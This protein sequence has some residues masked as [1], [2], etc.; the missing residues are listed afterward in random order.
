M[1]P[2]ALP[3]VDGKAVCRCGWTVPCAGDVRH[4]CRAKP[5]GLGDI[6]AGALASVG[7]T[8]E[9]VSAALG[10]PCKCGERQEVLN[11]IGRTVGIGKGP[12][13]PNSR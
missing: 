8:K 5:R 11:A 12:S 6:V 13:F 1:P 10:R 2:I 7:I 9:R 3:C 4:V